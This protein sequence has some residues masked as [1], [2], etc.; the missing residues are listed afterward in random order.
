[1]HLSAFQNILLIS[2]WAHDTVF[3]VF[4]GRNCGMPV[5]DLVNDVVLFSDQSDEYR[6]HH[7]SH[8]Y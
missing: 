4:I 2:L 1:M 5:N 8:Y 3:F 7:L 6:F